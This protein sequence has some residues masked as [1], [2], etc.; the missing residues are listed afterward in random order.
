MAKKEIYTDMPVYP[1]GDFLVWEQLGQFAIEFSPKGSVA[2]GIAQGKPFQKILQSMSDS[3]RNLMEIYQRDIE[4]AGYRVFSIKEYNDFQAVEA[5]YGAPTKGLG[6]A[7]GLIDLSRAFRYE[8]V[9]NVEGTYRTHVKQATAVAQAHKA[10]GFKYFKKLDKNQYTSQV[11]F[12]NGGVTRAFSE[13]MENIVKRYED[14]QTAKAAFGAGYRGAILMP[15]PTYG[16]FFYRLKDILKGHDIDLI[17]VR[18]NEDGSVNEISLKAA[19]DECRLK[20]TRALA[21]YDCNP[22]NPTGHVRQKA[23]TVKI[24]EILQTETDSYIRDDLN[25]IKK[26]IQDP[27]LRR[28]ENITRWLASIQSP[29]GG[30]LILDDMAYEGLEFSSRK[31]PYSFAQVSSMV[32]QYTAVLKGVSKIGLPGARIGLVMGHANLIE[33]M[34][35]RQLM[36]EFSASSL[37]VDI[38]TAR[39]GGQKSDQKKFRAHK[40]KLRRHHLRKAGIIEAFFRGLDNT[41]R[42]T[43]AQKNG[44]VQIY[45]RHAGIDKAE[46]SRRLKS[47]LPKFTLAENMDCGFFYPIHCDSLYGMPIAFKFDDSFIINSGHI[48]NS[49]TLHW[50]F[51]SFNM[52]T[53]PAVSQGCNPKAMSV[54]ITTSLPDQ[55]LLRFYGAMREMQEYFFGK[56][57]QAQLD[58]FR[59]NYPASA[60]G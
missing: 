31:K 32:A 34:T 30:I 8:P 29:Y 54:R 15:V 5:D 57:P 21:Y 38:I 55:E 41:D 50:V 59:K 42:L 20:N 28:D 13:L 2:E 49:N 53:V 40:E 43:P 11:H 10:K 16:L 52:H 12:V 14:Y 27:K 26:I 17:T 36:E 46:S 56:N 9:H 48:I 47:G 4:R 60:F 24:A 33:P 7:T 25:L 44:L 58:L 39:Y 22:Q 23:E 19:L 51:R 35:S 37:G 3:T 6:F 18:R 45:S 1:L